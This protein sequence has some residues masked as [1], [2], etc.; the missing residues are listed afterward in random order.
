MNDLGEIGEDALIKRLIDQLDSCNTTHGDLVVGPGDDC[1][2]A[3]LGLE[4]RYQLLKTDA[5]VE[6]IHYLAETAAD[7]VGW[8]AIARVISDFA[9]MGGLP[10]HLLVTI[11]MPAAKPVQYLEKLYQ[12]MQQCASAYGAV[13]CGG[14][15]SALPHGGAAVISVAG[16]GWVEKSRCVTRSGGRAQ[17][18]ILVTGKLG[19][20]IRGKHLTFTPRIEEA[21]WLTQKFQIHSM[22]DL[23]DG[24]GI[25][26]VR[27]ASASQCG[28]MIDE[29]ALPLNDTCSVSQA[30]G[31][32]EDYE[33][34]FS[35]SAE[36]VNQL[37][38]AWTK[39][40]PDLLLSVVGELYEDEKIASPVMEGWEHFKSNA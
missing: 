10:A 29:M 17:D 2:V 13:I 14:E 28:Y 21:R 24:L 23:S 33:L 34:L 16:T 15:T 11:A 19:G 32:G 4:D 30:L 8:K 6:G 27:L 18:L 20:S 36:T 3:D 1:A 25:D 12:G 35:A 39:Q 37:M 9:A 7:K 31:D 38:P 5:M 22:M 26:L 40:Y